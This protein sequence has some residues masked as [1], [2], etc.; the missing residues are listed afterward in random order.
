MPLSEE[1][2]ALIQRVVGLNAS[3]G[4]YTIDLELTGRCLDAA[5]AEAAATLERSE[6]ELT[7]Y[8]AE[9][10][11]WH[12]FADDLGLKLEA[13][14]AQLERVERERDEAIR[15]QDEMAREITGLRNSYWTERKARLAAEAQVEAMRTALEKCRSVASAV[16]TTLMDT[17]R[18]DDLLLAHEVQKADWAAMEALAALA[19]STSESSSKP[20]L[21]AD[22]VRS[23]PGGKWDDSAYEAVESA[24]DR[25]N[26][27]CQ[28]DGRWL[29]LAERVAALARDMAAAVEI[30][31]PLAI[32]YDN[33][34]YKPEHGAVQVPTPWGIYA[35]ASAFMARVD[36][37]ATPAEARTGQPE[38][39]A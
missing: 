20:E 25:A 8:G 2:Q 3:R 23:L 6:A 26:A 21:T 38:G 12:A 9:V 14:E 7:F 29:T 19:S 39:E 37:P 36:A 17:R 5:R 18:R 24:L 34:E 35:K 10:D 31:R 13:A 4:E 22:F 33:T 16:M 1:N 28:A 27:P 32:R 30:I 15:R 11:R